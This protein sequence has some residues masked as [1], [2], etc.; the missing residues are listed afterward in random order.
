MK[1]WIVVTA[2][3]L[4]ISTGCG[5]RTV[6]VVNNPPPSSG[7]VTDD[8]PAHDASTG[9]AWDGATW[10]VVR[11]HVHGP[12]CGHYHHH[13]VWHV[14]PENHVYAGPHHHHWGVTVHVR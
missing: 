1:S 8:G 2:A 3:A 6:V 4:L 5:R 13:G 14:Y 10:V 7:G 12:R 11:G 9:D